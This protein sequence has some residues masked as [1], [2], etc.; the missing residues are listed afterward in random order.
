MN[1]GS[2]RRPLLLVLASTYPRWRN[3]HEPAFVHELCRRLSARYR[4]IAVVPDA[5][6]ADPSGDLEGVQ[7]RRFRYAPRRL[8]TLVNDGGIVANLRRSRWKWLLVPGFVL[9]QYVEARRVLKYE[10]VDVIHAHWLIPQGLLA[11]RLGKHYRVPFVVTSHGG[12]LYGLRMPALV[13][14][15]RRVAAASAAMSVVSAAMLGEAENQGVH[16][17]RTTVL[18]MGVDLTQRFSPDASIRREDDRLLFVGRLVPKKGLCYLLEAMPGVVACRPQVHLTIAGFGPEGPALRR[19]AEELGLSGHVTFLGATVQSDLPGLYRQAALFV[20]PFVKDASGD[21][22]GLPVAL[23]E[24]VGCGCP[25]LAGRVAG[26][27]ELLGDGADDV[28]VEPRDTGQ[29]AA[30]ILAELAQPEQARMRAE[31]RRLSLGRKVDW[32]IIAD[33]YAELIETSCS[34]LV[35][36]LS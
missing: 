5:P 30:R 2:A 36:E 21:Q 28:I 32:Q 1:A 13:R 24:A 12:D 26:I 6:G 9:A 33:R 29:L 23:M 3:D 11:W 7:V 35:E 16:A 19:R 34:S 17:S 22:E 14:L 31:R 18:P 20:A 4:V 25:V 15:K 27:H 8:Q 10:R